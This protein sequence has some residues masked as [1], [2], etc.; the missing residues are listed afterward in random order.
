LTA[1]ID[2]TAKSAKHYFNV[3]SNNITSNII[4]YF[5]IFYPTLQDNENTEY[6]IILN[7]FRLALQSHQLKKELFLWKYF[8]VMEKERNFE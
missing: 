1:K 8:A 2:K 7:F 3:T 4:S 6:L 5:S